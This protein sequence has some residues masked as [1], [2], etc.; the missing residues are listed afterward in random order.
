MVFSIDQVGTINNSLQQDRTLVEPSAEAVSRM[1]NE[2]NSGEI[3]EE[4]QAAV[5]EGVEMFAINMLMGSMRGTS[6]AASEIESIDSS[7]DPEWMPE[8]A[9]DGVEAF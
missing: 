6:E 2:L 9:D 1:D 3:T 4:E 7:V 8:R 5:T